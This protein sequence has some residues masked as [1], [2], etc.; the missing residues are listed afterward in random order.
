MSYTDI[1][2][3]QLHDARRLVRAGRLAEAAHRFRQHL[4]SHPLHLESLHSLAMIYLQTGQYD[5]ARDCFERALASQPDHI[6]SLVNHATAL[7]ELKRLEEA[8]AGYDRVIAL[9]S[10]NAIAWNN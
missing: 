2:E 10:N 8:V 7:L 1:L 5:E 4:R 9:D 3:L 6:E